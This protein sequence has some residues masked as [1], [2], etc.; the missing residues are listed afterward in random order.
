MGYDYSRVGKDAT[1]L[2]H[3]ISKRTFALVSLDDP[4]ADLGGM[5]SANYTSL[6]LD[7]GFVVYGDIIQ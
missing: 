3:L 1:S 7:I 6:F 5:V 4:D 2:V